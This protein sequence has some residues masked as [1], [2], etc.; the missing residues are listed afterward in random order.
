MAEAVIFDMDGVIFDSERII[1][2]LWE[3]FGRENNIGNM[4]DVTI[5]CIGLN[6]KATEQVF[7]D[8]FGEEYDYQYF[9]GIISERAV[10]VF[11][12]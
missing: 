6:D 3:E 12:V 8:T 11:A 2:E 4:D 9:K 5:K 7:K 10:P 1:V